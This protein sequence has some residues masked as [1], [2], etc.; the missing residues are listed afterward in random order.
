MKKT[1]NRT[2]PSGTLNRTPSGRT[3]S[4]DAIKSETEK[5]DTMRT[6]F[7][8]ATS[9]PPVFGESMESDIYS[10]ILSQVEPVPKSS[11]STNTELKGIIEHPHPINWDAIHKL[12]DVSGHHNSC[13]Q[14]KKCCTMGLGFVDDGEGL[15]KI[16]NDEEARQLAE[17][18]LSGR[19]YVN[20]KVDDILN[21]LCTF[22]FYHQFNQIVEDFMD[23]G[24]GYMEVVRDSSDR[25]TALSFIPYGHLRAITYNGHLYFRYSCLG[26]FG[27]DKFFSMFG[28]SEKEWL[29]D[30]VYKNENIDPLSVSEIVPFILPSNR[31]RFYGYPDWVSACIDIE[32]LKKA[33]QYKSDFY[34]NRG[35]I[36]K[37]ISVIGECGPDTWDKLVLDIKGTVGGKRNF[38]TVLLNL[39]DTESTVNVQDLGVTDGT[40][41][42]YAADSETITQSIVSA[43]GVP[44]L[45]ANILIPGKLG[46]SNE[47]INSLISFQLL[48][49]NLYQSIIEKTL[50]ST[51]GSDE[52][53]EGLSED[54]FRLRTITGQI[55][56]LHMDTIGKMRSEAV[57]D[58]ERDLKKGVRD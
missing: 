6:A 5:K 13:I 11:N 28:L 23:M 21:P 36:D 58:P 17:S 37:F 43:H 56:V 4:V 30:T 18:M 40:E 24:Q 12:K 9:S 46:A 16:K 2:H 39:A 47:F 32:L 34:W 14:T 41:D 33:K 55:D 35:V 50:A 57:A 1:E 49:V 15:S 25:I 22:N 26:A 48:R 38:G 42:Q 3:P 8:E 10:M 54:D 7:R 31:Q 45:L 19:A 20:S 51:L 27:Q 53:V 44:P 52:G 29:M